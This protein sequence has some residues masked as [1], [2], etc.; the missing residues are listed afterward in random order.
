MKSVK[1]ALTVNKTQNYTNAN[2][3]VASEKV[4]S[5]LSEVRFQ[6]S[7]LFFLCSENFS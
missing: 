3:H 6:F 2:A 5:L 4:T 7:F 1:Q